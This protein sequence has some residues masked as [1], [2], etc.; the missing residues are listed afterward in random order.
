MISVAST[1]I[2]S[3]SGAPCSSQNALARP[4]VRG[5]QRVQQ[6][7]VAR[8]PV[9]HPKRGRV[10]R[11]RPEQRLLV[12]HRAQIGRGS[13]RRRRASPPDRGSPGQG[14]ARDGAA[15]IAASR[16]DS[17]PV[18]PSQSATCASSA[19]PACDTKPAPSAVTSTVT[20]RPSRITFKVNLPKLDSSTFASRRIAA[21]PDVPRP[22]PA[23]GAAV[24]ARS[25]LELAGN[26]TEPWRGYI[27]AGAAPQDTP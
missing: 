11:D 8:D 7:R 17:A 14:H 9:D 12:A 15:C 19:L 16:S 21:Q 2:V 25:G 1:S 18:S 26:F 20:R 24:T 4:R 10:R 5:A 22:P 3:R 27:A 23:G 13:R 6:L